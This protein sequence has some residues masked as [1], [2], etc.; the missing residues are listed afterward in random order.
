MDLPSSKSDDFAPL[1]REMIATQLV[2]RGITAPRVLAAFE[3]VPRELF[4][5]PEFRDQAYEDTALPIDA[6]QTISQPYIVA[7]MTQALELEGKERVLE[8]GTGTGYQTAILCELAQQV[9][10]IERCAI[11]ARQARTR[12]HALGYENLTLIEGDGTLGWPP[13]AP[14]DAILAAAAAREIPPALIDQLAEGGSLV[15][16]IGGQE[17]QMLIRLIKRHDRL[18]REDLCACRFVPLVGATAGKT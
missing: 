8:I 4:V 10:S 7:L 17:S 3:R 2:P 14:Y 1:R 15:L 5:S 18:Y 16:P 12:L 6:G 9:V 11:L 13:G